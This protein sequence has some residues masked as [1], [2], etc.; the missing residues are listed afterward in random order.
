MV[1]IRL[2]RTGRKKVANYRVVV[3]DSRKRRDGKVVESLGYYNPM[4]DPAEFKVDHTRAMYWLG[5]GA[6]MSDTVNSLFHRDGIVK[7]FQLAK[8]GMDAST[9]E[10]ERKP[11][12]KK[13][14][15]VSKKVLA[16]QKAEAAKKEETKEASQEDAPKE[17]EKK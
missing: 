16:K 3:M 2:T 13:K 15:S 4:S 7:K 12:R 10:I 1:V 11:E 8:K 9:I 14:A 17:E 6:Q 5:N